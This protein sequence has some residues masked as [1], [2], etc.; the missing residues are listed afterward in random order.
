MVKNI[1]L[2]LL[3]FTS[4]NIYA[5]CDAPDAVLSAQKDIAGFTPD[6]HITE[7]LPEDIELLQELKK[8]FFETDATANGQSDVYNRA[9][10][11]YGAQEVMLLT[12]DNQR[13]SSLYFK[14]KNAPVNIIYVTGYFNDLT[15]TK[16]WCAPFAALYPEFNILSFDWRGF[17]SSPGTHGAISG[18]FHKNSFGKNAY[19]DI[20]AAIDFMRKENDKPVILVGFCFGAA[21][22]M[23]AT[24][25]A[26]KSGKQTADALVLN[27]L[28][29][30]FRNQFDRAV[31][32]EDRLPYRLLLSSG[33]GESLLEHIINGSLFDM[34]PIN[35]IKDITMPLYFEHYAYDPFAIIQE[36][37]ELYQAATGPKM[38]TQSDIGRHVR[39]HGKVPF[40][41]R[42]AFLTFLSRFGFLPN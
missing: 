12:D 38:F 35:M 22:A 36:G 25:E 19:P 32:A 42:Q 26:Q 30:K 3:F 20:Q 21:M 18:I 39:I 31:A 7:Q 8:L 40:Q 6:I 10:K 15:P 11:E 23:H 5:S 41:Y 4:S 14:R 16:E 33:I 24:V 2:L 29:T 17:G 34:S 27:C 28:F 1:A 13:I 37:V 9:V